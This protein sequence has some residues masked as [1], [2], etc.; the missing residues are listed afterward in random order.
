MKNK[1]VLIL[2]NIDVSIYNTRRELIQLLIDKGYEVCISC[3]YGERVEKLKDIGCKYIKTDFSRH[4]TNPISELKLIEFYR[5]SMKD[6]KPDIV[7]TYSIKQNIYGGIAANSL[8]I[9]YLANITGLGPALE[10]DGI[11]RKITL[12]M[13]RYA[14]R[15]VKCV[16]F[17]NEQNLQFF[18]DQK[19]NIKNKKLIPGSGVNLEQFYVLDYPSEETTEFV[20]ISRIMKEK[21][22]DQYLGAASVIRR[23][24]PNTRFHICGFCEDEY[25]DK[26]HHLTDDGDVI[27]H[28]MIS[29]VKDM[30]QSIHCT[31]HP[32]FYPEG[33][34]NVLLESCASGRPVITTDRSGCR[35]IVDDGVNGYVVEQQ[36]SQDL[37]AKIEMFLQLDYEAKKQIGLEGRK[38]VEN[39][40]DRQIVVNAYLE[41]I[42]KVLS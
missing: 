9:P 5:K 15:K 4:G 19:V 11:L 22:I 40:F 8:K 31:V 27:Y 3:L 36:N 6:L 18:V 7:L 39:E 21:G 20:F 17:Q 37:I 14:F 42:K 32:S 13:Y 12:A 38:K 23:K 16:F 25:K 29:D 34:S 1:K 24:Y 41:E 2:A 26:M 10:N 33:M 35:E 28:G 30:L